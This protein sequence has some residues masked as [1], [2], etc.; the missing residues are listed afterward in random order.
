M[1]A[2]DDN[3]IWWVIGGG[4]VIWVLYN[5][6]NPPAA[7]G[8]PLAAASGTAAATS[9]QTVPAAQPLVPAQGL[10]VGDQGV[11]TGSPFAPDTID[12]TTGLAPIS[13]PVKSIPPG[14]P[15]NVSGDGRMNPSGP[16]AGYTGEWPN[17]DGLGSTYYVNGVP[18]SMTSGIVPP[19]TGGLPYQLPSPP[20]QT[21]WGGGNAPI[22]I[23]PPIKDNGDDKLP[24]GVTDFGPAQQETGVF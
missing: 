5:Y 16:P 6:M 20:E 11:E 4:L 3:T 18:R 7:A 23:G 9:A 24:P 22:Y 8:A 15:L 19:P 13:L 17:P 2:K 21:I 14:T 10:V 1:P 12:P